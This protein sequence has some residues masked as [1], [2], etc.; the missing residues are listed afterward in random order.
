MTRINCI[1]VDQ[2]LDQHLFAE[3]RE[4]T[5]VA[6]LQRSL[7]SYGVYCMGAGHVKFFYNKGAFLRRRTEQLYRELC[8]RGYNAMLK[9][10]PAH[11]SAR[12]KDWQ[13]SKE[14]MLC[15]LLRLVEKQRARPGFYKL[16]GNPAPGNHYLELLTKL[17]QDEAQNG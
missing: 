7:S 4:I 16:Q 6:S 17:T 15:N 1:P 3:Y 13:P 10:Y 8:A 5:R 9:V 14:D 12:D 11:G 2:L